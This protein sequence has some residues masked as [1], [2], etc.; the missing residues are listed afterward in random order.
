MP[1]LLSVILPVL[2]NSAG[3]ACAI[4]SILQ[5]QDGRLELIVI[6]GGS[7]DGTLEMIA[8]RADRIAYW[9][10]GLDS[11]I[12]DA[13][14]RGISRATGEFV[15]ILNSDDWWEPDTFQHFTAA[16]AHD[17]T[18][19]VLYG[20]VRYVDGTNNY[21]YVRH[22]DLTAMKYRMWLFHPA[23]LVRRETYQRIGVYN[24]RYTH[25]M[26]SEW[27]HRALAAGIHFVRIPSVLANMALGGISD[28][29]YQVSLRQYRD[30]LIQHKVCT[31]VEAYI[32]YSFFSAL[33]SAM[34]LGW[35][36]PLKKLRDH[37]LR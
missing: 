36:R 4:D 19:A 10:S 37:L 18:A 7:T 17:R 3:F 16:L 14:N 23:I 24:P 34:L 21:S 32:Y 12:A 20:S 1:P 30:S 15:A 13:F 22:P 35:L 2:N 29:Q 26:D 33:K 5:Q 11:G 8:Q 6:D 28:R 31:Q 9:E 25:A 27:C